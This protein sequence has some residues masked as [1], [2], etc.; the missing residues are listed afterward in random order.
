[1]KLYLHSND[2]CVKTAVQ[3]VINELRPGFSLEEAPIARF[4]G[5]MILWDY[6]PTEKIPHPGD[7]YNGQVVFFV[8]RQYVAQLQE[9]LGGIPASILLKP[10]NTVALKS[11]IELKSQRGADPGGLSGQAD[12]LQYLLQANLKLQEFDHDRT[13]FLARAVHDFRAPLT[14]LHGY[15]GLLLQQQLGVL[16]SSQM[17]LL[18]RM[19]HSIKRLSRMASSMFELSVGKHVERKPRLEALDVEQCV[20]HALHDVL[21]LADEKN[22]EVSVQ[23][24]APLTPP[25]WEGTQIEQ[26]LVNLFENA[27]KFTPR[28]GSIEVRGYE[29]VMH[30]GGRSE[31]AVHRGITQGVAPGTPAYRIDVHDTGPGVQRDILPHIFEEYTSYSGGEDRSGGGLGLA[32]CRMIINVHGGKIWA[33]S[34]SEGATFSFILPI[35]GLRL[36]TNTHEPKPLVAGALA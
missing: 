9:E 20:Q 35:S 6:E 1:M 19:Q 33:E 2:P 25:R 23:I 27:C 26:V 32:I 30:V 5:Q 15:C 29:V 22:I 14:A 16:N 36:Q 28:F 3:A 10:L 18:Q 7:G 31:S 8:R 24:N 11:M 21:P 12:L 17:E 34:S 4:T 13:N